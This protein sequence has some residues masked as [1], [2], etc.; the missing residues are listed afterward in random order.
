MNTPIQG[1][2]ADIIKVAM[3]EVTAW[4]AK[5][6]GRARLL[7]QVHDD[8]LFDVPRGELA[9]L[10]PAVR[11]LM[12]SAVPLDVPVVV[13]LKTGPNWADMKKGEPAA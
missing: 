8:L 2:S 5:H 12:E 11:R 7:L 3:R 4:M 10:A 1:T 13:D 6:G 9:A